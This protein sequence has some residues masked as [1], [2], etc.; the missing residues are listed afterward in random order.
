MSKEH[1][2]FHEEA[3]GGLINRR[4][5]ASIN[6]HSFYEQF[7][8]K[9]EWWTAVFDFLRKDLKTMEVGKYNLVGD[10]VFAMIS[11][12]TTKTLEDAKW[13]A[14]RKYIDLQYLI[15][16]EEKMGVLPLSAAVSAEKYDAEKDLIFY[17]DHDGEYFTANPTMF[18]L[19]FPDDVH[20]PGIQLE[21]EAPVKKLVIKIAVAE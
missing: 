1:D 10:Q 3:W 14:H 5:H 11:E 12:Y 20:R 15:E 4:A 9:P 16:G 17:G 2:W 8:L 7:H 13:E 18:F 19:F 6:I 21:R